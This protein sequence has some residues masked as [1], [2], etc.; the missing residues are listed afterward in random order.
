MTF[1]SRKQR[2]W[3]KEHKPEIYEQFK[4]D[5]GIKVVKAKDK[6]KSGSR[7]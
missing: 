4:K 2:T 5:G 6:K 7:S 1:Y 3:L